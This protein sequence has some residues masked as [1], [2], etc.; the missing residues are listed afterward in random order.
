M[1]KSQSFLDQFVL[2][3]TFSRPL[4][5]D[6]FTQLMASLWGAESPEPGLKYLAAYAEA[7]NG[8]SKDP[9]SQRL[10]STFNEVILTRRHVIEKVIKNS[11]KK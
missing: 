9:R 11:L 8:S 3:L 7:G 6:E 5:E 10:F 1:M 2:Y 4:I